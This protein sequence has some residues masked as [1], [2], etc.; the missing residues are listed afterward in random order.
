[1]ADLGKN[2]YS[3]SGNTEPFITSIVISNTNVLKNLDYD[4]LGAGIVAIENTEF[5]NAGLFVRSQDSLTGTSFTTKDINFDARSAANVWVLDIG[6]THTKVSSVVY[7]V[8]T[9]LYTVTVADS[10]TVVAGTTY[11]V[12]GRAVDVGDTTAK[13]DYQIGDKVYE[14]YTDV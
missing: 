8:P 4:G 10:V 7:D 5:K 9:G 2:G 13:Q 1:M 6:G 12:S 14:L 3:W 11:R